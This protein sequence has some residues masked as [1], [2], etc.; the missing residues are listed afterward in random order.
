M[1]RQSRIRKSKVAAVLMAVMAVSVTG[2]FGATGASVKILSPKSGARVSGEISVSA[3]VRA[4]SVAYLILVVDGDRPCVTNSRPYRF[5]LD[6]RLLADGPHKV[7]VEA[8]DSFGM[9]ASSR[10]IKIYVKNGTAAPLAA[11]KSAT[12]RALAKSPSAADRQA[13][14]APAKT[15]PAPARAK[16]PRVIA[17]AADLEAPGAAAGTMSG[18]GPLPE[19]ASVAAEEGQR[20]RSLAAPSGASFARRRAN[21]MSAIPPSAP[22]PV[23][24]TIMLDGKVVAFDVEPRLVDGRLEAGF[25]ALFTAAGGRVIW[26]AKRKTAR[27]VS[28]G[29]VVEVPIGSETATVNG[30]TVQMPRPAAVKKGRTIIPVRFFAEATG[31]AIYWDSSTKVASLS[32][33]RLVRSARAEQ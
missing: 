20:P 10:A 31:A 22:R 2:L 12:T 25:R 29:L 18:R 28:P 7:S 6:T 23:G 30:S 14:L 16:G 24:H 17:Q 5:D 1:S 11:K 19:P 9:I 15:V 26:N 4:S 33:H 27:S 32:T 3:R 8:Y 21:V 13:A